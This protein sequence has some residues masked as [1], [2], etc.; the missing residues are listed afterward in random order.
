M[1]ARLI[2]VAALPLALSACAVGSG[3]GWTIGP[4][5]PASPGAR[6]GDGGTVNEENIELTYRRTVER[7]GLSPQQ[8]AVIRPA[9][10]RLLVGLGQAFVS[11]PS[12]VF[13]MMLA[14]K[15]RS[16]EIA[17]RALGPANEEWARAVQSTLR[18]DQL[19]CMQAN[20]ERMAA[21]NRR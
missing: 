17:K 12:L 21:P 15:K 19:A 16:E 10:R 6:A 1:R 14:G 18:P 7:C 4:G 2:A 20:Q 9:Y 8:D 3:G 13:R 5:A 11:D